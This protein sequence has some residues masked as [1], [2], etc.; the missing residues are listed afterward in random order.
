MDFSDKKALMIED[1]K[2]LQQVMEAYFKIE[3]VNLVLAENGLEGIE[4][5]KTEKPD[6]VLTDLKMPGIDGLEVVKSINEISPEVPVIIMSGAGK[7]EDSIDALRFGAWDYL[8][9]PC[10][11]TAV[12]RVVK[13]AFEHVELVRENQRYH[14]SLEEEVVKRTEELENELSRRKEA[15]MALFESEQKFR[16]IFDQAFHFIAL[17]DN[18]GLLLELNDTARN[19]IGREKKTV[20]GSQ[21]WNLDWWGDSLRQ[22]IIEEAI[23]KASKGGF[24]S[25]ETIVDSPDGAPIYID[26][27]L[28]PVVDS[29]G[30]VVMII[31][32]GIDVTGHKRIES[33]LTEAKELAEKS[34]AAKSEFLSNMSHEIRTPM[35]WIL[36]Y[37]KFGLDKALSADREKLHS[38]FRDINDGGKRLMKLLDNLLDLSKMESGD[39]A[40]E[41]SL[42][43]LPGL[44]D[45]VCFRSAAS[46]LE[47]GLEV[48]KSIELPGEISVI[49]DSCKIL[50]VLE[51]YLSNALQFSS[52]N[53]TIEISLAIVD[54]EVVCGVADQ[55]C[56]VPSVEL[57]NVFDKFFQSSKTK[58]GAGGIGLGLAICSDIIRAHEGRVWAEN[59]EGRGAVFYFSLPVED[60]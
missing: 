35:H 9:K 15:E 11:P 41:R 38:F 37:S 26:L 42:I 44:V 13:K 43:D 20:V 10:R 31:A 39:M 27:T 21:L 24:V 2:V 23:V 57:G 60:G 7:M 30:D 54:G 34:N 47:R 59:R 40:Y 46:M 12:V 4:L 33:E 18:H 5:F 48:K 32:E 16:A 17:T 19:Y 56:G 3:N 51:N 45:Q 6:V 52:E 53:S 55:G 14:D 28:K 1:D 50:Q 36:S 22:K 8:E 25:F 58:T 29:G 49:G